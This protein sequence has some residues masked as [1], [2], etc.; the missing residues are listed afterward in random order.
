MFTPTDLLLSANSSDV[1]MF[2]LPLNWFIENYKI[3]AESLQLKHFINVK[4]F[5]ASTFTR[6]KIDDC[7]S[8]QVSVYGKEERANVVGRSM[9]INGKSMKSGRLTTDF[10]NKCSRCTK[11]SLCSRLEW[12]INLI[13]GDFFYSLKQE[14]LKYG[15]HACQKVRLPREALWIMTLRVVFQLCL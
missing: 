15:K 3:K 14:N 5:L 10:I 4:H 9:F 2:R 11:F 1:K 13:E 7:G 8:Q 12:A 6:S